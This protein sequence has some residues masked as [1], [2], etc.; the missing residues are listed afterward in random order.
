MV[1]CHA[2]NCHAG[3]LGSNPGGLELSLIG[4]FCVYISVGNIAI[5]RFIFVVVV[6]YICERQC[7]FSI[8]GEWWRGL[9]KGEISARRGKKGKTINLTQ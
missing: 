8:L 5:Y 1:N 2:V 3:V 6:L 9:S 7:F 4:H